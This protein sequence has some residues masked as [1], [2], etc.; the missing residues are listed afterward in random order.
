MLSVPYLSVLGLLGLVAALP[1]AV[2]I[3]GRAVLPGT[4]I[5]PMSKDGGIITNK[6]LDAKGGSTADGTPVQ[7]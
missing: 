4:V 7:M 2:D 6:C 5:H 3:Q 1:Q